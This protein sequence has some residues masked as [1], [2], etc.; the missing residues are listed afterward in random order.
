MK[1]YKRSL[2]NSYINSSLCFNFFLIDLTNKYIFKTF[3]IN[4]LLKTFRRTT[5]AKDNFVDVDLV[6]VK[7]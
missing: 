3:K 4:T 1:S 6:R 2:L 5:A 7:T